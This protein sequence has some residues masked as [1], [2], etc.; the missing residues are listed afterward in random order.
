VL[1]SGLVVLVLGVIVFFAWRALAS[2]KRTE[3]GP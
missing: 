3:V 2:F 1:A